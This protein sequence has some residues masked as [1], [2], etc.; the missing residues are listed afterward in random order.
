LKMYS[1]DVPVYLELNTASK[2]NV[3]I[4][5][6]RSLYVR[7]NENLLNEIKSLLGEKSVGV[8]L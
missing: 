3:Q 8:I 4:V 6:G 5:V 2:K 7:P 1:G